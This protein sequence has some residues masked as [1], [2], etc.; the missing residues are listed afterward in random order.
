[1]HEGSIFAKEVK[2]DISRDIV[3]PLQQEKRRQSHSFTPGSKEGGKH[4]HNSGESEEIMAE[5]EVDDV[6]LFPNPFPTLI[7]TA[8]P[9]LQGRAALPGCF[10]WRIPA[11]FS[12]QSIT[13]GLALPSTDTRDPGRAQGSALL[14]APPK[15]TFFPGL[16]DQ[17]FFFHSG[18]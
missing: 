14:P 16:E 2:P 9:W 13:D 4:L 10:P 7:S 1:M 5:L 15:L 6:L 18:C 11:R 3:H 12:F 8:W 17:T